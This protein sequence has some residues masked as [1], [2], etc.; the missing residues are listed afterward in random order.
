MKAQIMNTH[1]P[2]APKPETSQGAIPAE[3]FLTTYEVQ[4]LL[5][6][7]HKQTI[8]KLI[9]EG[10]PAIKIGKDYR[11]IRGEVIGYLKNERRV[12][13]SMSTK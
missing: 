11:F 9:H 8:Y 12:H 13:K 5:K 1:R 3:E 7:K 6:I 2:V 4:K 10:M